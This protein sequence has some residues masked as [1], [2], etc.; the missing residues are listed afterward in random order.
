MKQPAPNKGGN[1][2]IWYGFGRFALSDNEALVLKFARPE[3]RLWSVQWLTD[4]WYEPDDL[5]ARLTGITGAEAHVDDDDHVRIVFAAKDPQIRNWLD[6][7]GYEKG[8]FVT[9]WIWCEN[10]PATELKVVPL[11]ELGAHLPSSTPRITQAGRADQIGR[12]RTHF[13]H[14]R[15]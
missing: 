13:V 2:H 10:G 8:L 7:S 15:R 14:R 9:R 11:S 3:A 1:S 5:L 4:P 12:R 6:V